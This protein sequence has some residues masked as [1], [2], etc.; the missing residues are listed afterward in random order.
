M[1]A[2]MQDLTPHESA[3]HFFGAELRHRRLQVG[4]SQA[5]LAGKVLATSS[6]LNKIEL[7]QRFPSADLAVRC[8]EVLRAGGALIR[9]QAFAAAER[10][11]S[12]SDLETP[13]IVLSELEA[14]AL[15]R[16][17]ATL[18][19]SSKARLVLTADARSQTAPRRIARR[20]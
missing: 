9:L 16:L 19:G 6:L 3:Q 14:V 17:L 10:A 5:V 13:P 12:D 7:G 8:D 20:S 1:G 15:R 18:S 2:R 11:R 4:L